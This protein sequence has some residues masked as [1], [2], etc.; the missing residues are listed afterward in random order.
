M[1]EHSLNSNYDSD[2]HISYDAI[3]SIPLKIPTKSDEFD[4]D[5]QSCLCEFYHHAKYFVAFFC[6][7]I[8]GIIG[9]MCLIL[10]LAK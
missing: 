3:Y 9:I 7:V 8:A 2:Y 6:L 4:K 5:S 10:Y 1:S